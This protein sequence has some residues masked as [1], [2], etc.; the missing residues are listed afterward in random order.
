M[1]R[2]NAQENVTRYST[3]KH[4]QSDCEVAFDY[5]WIL[6]QFTQASLQLI[7]CS[8]Y[9]NNIIAR[10]WLHTIE[11]FRQKLAHHE[12]KIS[13]CQR[14]NEGSILIRGFNRQESRR[15]QATSGELY[16]TRQFTF[17]ISIRRTSKIPMAQLTTVTAN[18]CKLIFWVH[19]M[20]SL[21]NTILVLNP[22]LS[23]SIPD[24]D[25][26]PLQL[27]RLVKEAEQKSLLAWEHGLI[28]IALQPFLLHLN[29]RF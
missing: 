25:T 3:I 13:P 26:T 14:K 11:A 18:A 29:R 19:F 9:T 8:M 27:S 1:K 21:R 16:T 20:S 5:W 24:T 17:C 2:R 7:I 12:F 23:P 22:F 15:N 6:K 10:I 4:E 28:K